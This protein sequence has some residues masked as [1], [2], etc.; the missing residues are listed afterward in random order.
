MFLYSDITSVP[1]WPDKRKIKLGSVSGV[2]LD[3]IGNV[4]VFHRGDRI[5]DATT[6]S[7]E[8]VFNRI[9]LGPISRPTVA[10]IH[11]TT[12]E[13]MYEWGSQMYVFYCI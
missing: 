10:I 7:L 5:W 6:F 13:L 2:A 9:D 1:E 4:Y 12:G 8:Y 3:T 11:P